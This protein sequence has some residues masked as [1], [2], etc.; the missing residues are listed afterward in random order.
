MRFLNEATGVYTIWFATNRFSSY[1][2]MFDRILG[3]IDNDAENAVNA[4]D[5]VRLMKY[6]VDE[7]VVVVKG[8]TDINGDGR[9]N[10]LDVL[11]LVRYLA[12]HEVRLY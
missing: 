9:T 10:I 7:T 6:V 1:L 5:V 2:L 8:S 12:G 3:D 11:R 4:L